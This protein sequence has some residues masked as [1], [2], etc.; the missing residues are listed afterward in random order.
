METEGFPGDH[1]RVI[2]METGASIGP[3]AIQR[4]WE[5]LG[6]LC[7]TTSPMPFSSNSAE[8]AKFDERGWSV[9]TLGP[10]DFG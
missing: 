5:R 1:L 9:C 2:K 10:L 6:A 7:V 8:F 3:N 4:E